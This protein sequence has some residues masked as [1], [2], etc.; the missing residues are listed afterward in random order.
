ME[1]K[2][3][4]G[5]TTELT[6]FLWDIRFNNYREWFHEN[7]N[8]YVLLLKDPIYS[9]AYELQDRIKE[10]TGKNLVPVVSRINRDIRF[11]K[12]KEP[13]RDHMWIVFKEEEESNW[14]CRPCL[15]FELT[16]KDYRLGAGAYHYPPAYMKAFRNKVDANV[17]GFKRLITPYDKAKQ[18]S[19]MGDTYKKK[20]QETNKP[21][22]VLNWYKRKEIALVLE[23]ELDPVFYSRDIVDFCSK[24]FKFLMPFFDYMSDIRV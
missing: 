7:R 13:Y 15:F 1:K 24:E 23:R 10:E 21:E 3:F 11:S 12:N 5:F 6:D 19:I 17:D 9:L 14:Q 16:P 20:L 22:E 18:Y 8:R 4:E 2:P